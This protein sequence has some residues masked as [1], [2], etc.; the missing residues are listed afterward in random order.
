MANLRK[1]LY[2]EYYGSFFNES[3]PLTQ[4]EMEVNARYIFSYLKDKGWTNNSISALLGNMQAESSL[5]SGRWQSDDGGWYSGGYSLVQ[6][7][8]VT[9][10]TNWCSENGYNDPSE[11]DNA[12]ARIIWEVE[13]NEQFY[14]TSNYPITFKE[15]TTSNAS[16]QYLA[17]SFLINYERPKDQRESVKQYRGSLAKKWY[18]FLT[19]VTPSDPENPT[20][21]K[22]KNLSKLLLFAT[23][24]D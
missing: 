16:V 23:I 11:I 18:E 8:P 10:Y 12:L 2:G 15:F 19:G 5:N 24:L 13:N 4:S 1:G 6:W 17:E 7:T 20:N 14:A 22:Y 3:E 21:K 9:K